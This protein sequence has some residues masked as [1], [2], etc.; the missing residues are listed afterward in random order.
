MGNYY[1]YLSL[2]IAVLLV[3]SL[4]SPI[5]AQQ[6]NFKWEVINWGKPI[7]ALAGRID[8]S[9]K[10]IRS[11]EIIGFD[12]FM[13]DKRERIHYYVENTI[14]KFESELSYNTN[15][16]LRVITETTNYDIRF[17]TTDLPKITE[18][19]ESYLIKVPAMP[20]KG[21][22][23]PYYLRIPSNDYKQKNKNSRR[24]LM[25]DTTNSGTADF[26]ASERWVVDTLENMSQYSARFA[27]MLWT[28]MLMPVIPRA[29]SVYVYNGEDYVTYEHA[30][31]REVAMHHIKL[32][33]PKLKD[34]LVDGYT[35]KGYDV[36]DFVK[37]DEQLIA[38]FNHAVEYLNENNFNIQTDKMFMD[39]F[40][41]SG[42]F[43]DRFTAMHPEM[44]KAV[45][46]GSTL[47]DMILPIKEYKGEK[48]IYPIGIYDYKEITGKQYDLKKQ[49]QVARLIYRGDIDR[50][51]P[52]EY[53]YKDSYSDFEREI[54]IKLWG[55]PPTP[56][57]KALTKLYGE[58]GGKGIFILDRGIGHSRSS[59]MYDYILEFFKANRDGDTPVYPIPKHPEQLQ[60]TIYK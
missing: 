42:C 52:V 17:T 15:Y 20:E 26:H 14:V 40:S 34:F 51:N 30:L 19:N 23:W 9:E 12:I 38:M 54:I 8:L 24:Y 7:D 10:G 31:D 44:V 49:N 55:L 16:S 18:A 13:G 25:V 53:G 37:L 46:S 39:G 3:L 1:R 2:I 4:S 50:N 43:N 33:D 22:N 47:T 48:L 21:F 36:Y 45:A 58:S 56:R 6:N 60:Y 41:A 57:A 28:P 11:G 59:E 35:L 29:S 5:L 27:E 32:Q